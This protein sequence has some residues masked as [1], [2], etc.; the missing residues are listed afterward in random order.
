MWKPILEDALRDEAIQS[1]KKI[2]GE[3]CDPGKPWAGTDDITLA[4]GLPGYTLLHA[5][6]EEAMADEGFSDTA[7]RFL[8][9]TIEIMSS[10]NLS[11]DLYSGSTGIAWTVVH[12]GAGDPDETGE[13]PLGEI[14]ELLLEHTKERP[15]ERHY[16]LIS[17]LVGIGVYALEALPKPRARACLGEIVNRL[18]E[19]ALEVDGGITWKTPPELLPEWQR[20]QA[21]KG[22]YNL[23]LAHGIPGIWGVL[24]QAA[25]EGIQES[26]CLSLLEK[27]IP[28]LLEQYLPD[29][30]GFPG[31][32]PVGKETEKS[33]RSAW[34]YGDHGIAISLF[35]AARLLGNTDW[36][37]EAL[38]IAR[39]VADA[40]PEKARVKDPGICHGSAGLGHIFNRFYQATEDAQF[41]EAARYWFGQTLEFRVPDKGIAGYQMLVGDKEWQDDPGMLTGACGIGLAL[42]SAAY[43]VEPGWDRFLLTAVPDAE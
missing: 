26:T 33:A 30:N 43:P 23:G 42:L 19:L 32:I 34:C 13:D 8:E 39:R 15:W 4:G 10:K 37:G 31:W 2:A 14:D 5:Y 41:L 9:K 12:V 21:P 28:W 35:S 22:Y 36:E 40:P 3:I 29:Q 16:D 18:S 27:S 6:L 38:K 24:A 1:I 7:T 11:P 25:S 20:E 17:G